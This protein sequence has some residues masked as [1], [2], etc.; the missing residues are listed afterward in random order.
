MRWL[1]GCLAVTVACGSSPRVSSMRLSGTF[2][3]RP[4]TCS[5]ELHN[6]N[7]DG[8]MMESHDI[9]GIVNIDGAD[10]FEPPNAP[11]LLALL[12]PQACALGG[13]I[14]VVVLVLGCTTA[15]TNQLPAEAWGVADYANVGLRVDEP[16]TPDDYTAAASVLQQQSAGHRERLPRFHGEKSGVVFAKLVTDLPDDSSVPI[17]ERFI[18]HVKRGQAIDAISKLYVENA[19][20][21]PSRE[22]IELTGVSLREAVVLATIADAFLASF[23]PDDPKREVRLEGLAKMKAGYGSMLLGGLLVAD[24]LRVPEHDRV[25]M[26]AHVATA[27]PALLPFAAPEMQRNIR[28]VIAKQLATFP[29]GKLHDAIVAVEQALPK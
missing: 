11:R 8:P 1:V 15:K 27:L 26:L 3:A 28:D 12:K 7:L 22:W 2:P 25:A 9:V 18:A 29:A 10:G 21:T 14:G 20:A 17:N 23:G 24:Q 16:W 6:G 5:L 13:E 4:S 19:F